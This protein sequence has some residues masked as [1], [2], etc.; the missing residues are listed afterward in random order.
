M[1]LTLY[2]S[3]Q[4]AVLIS[5][6]EHLKGSESSPGPCICASKTCTVDM[7]T[8]SHTNYPPFPCPV[9]SFHG[10]LQ[11]GN[12]HPSHSELSFRIPVFT[13]CLVIVQTLE[14]RVGGRSSRSHFEMFPPERWAQVFGMWSAHFSLAAEEGLGGRAQ[15][16]PLHAACPLEPEWMGDGRAAWW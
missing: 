9:G 3:V 6:P 13:F 16:L 10:Y 4:T 7:F 15:V 8:V 2:L 12:P 14:D 11:L 1:S 5:S